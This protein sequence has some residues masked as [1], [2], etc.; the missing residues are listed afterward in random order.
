MATNVDQL[1]KP[2]EAELELLHVLWDKGPSTVAE[3]HEKV[4]M[5]KDT[6]YTTTLKILQIMTGK[7]LVERRLTGK[8]HIYTSV[9]SRE[10][11]QN[12]LV[13]RLLQTAFHGSTSTM[14][15]QA[16]GGHAPG[17]AEL[18]EIRTLLDKLEGESKKK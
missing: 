14:V 10:A 15:M 6:G 18:A 9:I 4:G 11:A 16:L 1:P 3:V 17:K 12:K 8:K 13:N 5:T 7:G 2:T